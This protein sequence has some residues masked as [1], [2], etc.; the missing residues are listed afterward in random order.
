MEWEVLVSEGPDGGEPRRST[1]KYM[2]FRGKEQ[3]RDE[4]NPQGERWEP[5][6][7]V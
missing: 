4:K 3:R 2:R 1:K 5:A 7:G 6:Q